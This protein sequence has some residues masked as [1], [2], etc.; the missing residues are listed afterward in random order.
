MVSRLKNHDMYP[1]PIMFDRVGSDAAGGSTLPV[2]ESVP[3]GEVIEVG[4][5]ETW[6]I[7]ADVMHA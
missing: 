7:R 1:A 5:R 2:A 6:E 4:R 3:P